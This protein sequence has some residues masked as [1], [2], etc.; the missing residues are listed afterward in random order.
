[1]MCLRMHDSQ[2]K[3]PRLTAG[4]RING[5]LLDDGAIVRLPP[6]EAARFA[7]LLSPGQ[8]I[9]VEGDVNASV[10]GRVIDATAIGA[11]SA[12]LN[13]VDAPPRLPRPGGPEARWDAPPPP[14][15]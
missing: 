11:S 5:A 8:T 2:A 4:F 15:R 1:V 12:T 9:S 10:L 3:P 14:R 6:P 13:P 7:A